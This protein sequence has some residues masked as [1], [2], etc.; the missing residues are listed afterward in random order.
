MDAKQIST[1]VDTLKFFIIAQYRLLLSVHDTEHQRVSQLRA[2][3]FASRKIKVEAP[4]VVPKA[5][6]KSAPRAVPTSAT[7]ATTAPAPPSGLKRGRDDKPKEAKPVE[8]EKNL[9]A[10]DLILMAKRVFMEAWK[11]ITSEDADGIFAA[12]VRSDRG[13]RRRSISRI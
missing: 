10:K 8:Q 9:S 1:I 7:P 13:W 4:K 2:T 11:Y 3:Y 5:I 6:N 12:K